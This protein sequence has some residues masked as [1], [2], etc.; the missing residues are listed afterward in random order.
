MKMNSILAGGV[1]VLLALTSCNSGS[2]NK[3]ASDHEGHAHESAPSQ[4]RKPKFKQEKTEAVYQHYSH[5]KSALVNSDAK[6]A[7]SGASMLS[8]AFTD[9][10]NN[11][12]AELAGKIAGS[13]DLKA[14]R[15]NFDEVTAEVESLIKTGGLQSGTVYKQYCP[16]AKD[17]D[18]AYWLASETD[19][20]NPYYGDEMLECGEVKEEIK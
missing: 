5:L 10:G 11:R 17:G 2:S 1:A 13:S 19:I 12:G 15:E 18:G 14:Q 16:M 8:A 6:E 4:A 20:K 7:Q 3:N 9:A